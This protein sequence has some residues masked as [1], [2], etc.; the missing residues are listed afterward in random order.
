[1]KFLAKKHRNYYNTAPHHAQG[2]LKLEI[3]R[4]W[5]LTAARLLIDRINIQVLGFDDECLEIRHANDS[6]TTVEIYATATVTDIAP[7]AGAEG[8]EGM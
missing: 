4:R 8:G 7:M 6:S 3:Y 2:M 1:M 5:G